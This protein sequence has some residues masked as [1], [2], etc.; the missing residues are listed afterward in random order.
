MRTVDQTD[1]RREGTRPRFAAQIEDLAETSSGTDGVVKSAWVIERRGRRRAVLPGGHLA[2]RRELHLFCSM[3]RAMS[4]RLRRATAWVVL[5]V[6]VWACGGDHSTRSDASTGP[7]RDADTRDAPSTDAMPSD[8]GTA[9]DGPNDGAPGMDAVLEDRPEPAPDAMRDAASADAA[10][11]ASSDAPPASC[12]PP[13]LPALRLERLSG[14]F[15]QPVY[16]T[17]APGRPDEHYVV[18]RAG[19]IVRV[20]GS[21]SS[22]FLDISARVESGMNEQ[23]L[24]GLAFHPDYSRNGR[25]FVYY[26]ARSANED[27]VVAEYRRSGTDPNA[28]DPTEIRRLIELPDPQWNHNGGHLAFGPDGMLWV[29]TGDGGGGCDNGPG[30]GTFGHAQNLMSLFGKLLRLDPDAA[31]SG[32]AAVGNPFADGRGLPQIWAYGLRNPWRWS[33]DRDT[34]DLF[35]G[36]VGQNAWEEIS[37]APAST[38]YG[39]GSNY[40]WR[41]YEGRELASSASGCTGMMARVDAHHEPVV[42]FGHGAR[43]LLRG[44]CSVTGGYVYRGRAI[45][46]LRG[47]YLFGDYCSNDFGAVRSCGGG[48][49]SEPV[50]FSIEG[51]GQPASFGEDLEGEL[52]VVRLDGTV[53]RIV[54]R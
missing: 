45:P 47:V 19:R 6:F 1:R 30:H 10:A 40:G 29:G 54:A 52:Y 18:E 36:D 37:L 49:V 16:V 14:T 15:R 11:D 17:Q 26:T 28:A 27:N 53:G 7:G 38:S 9:L 21:G 35:I 39:R 5:F 50:R 41:V 33:F 34:G 4:A 51:A 48:R 23:G 25:F 8:T 31:S 3:L 42:V 32:F 22:T 44:A 13:T 43:S 24:L 12:D 20:T 46:A 2:R